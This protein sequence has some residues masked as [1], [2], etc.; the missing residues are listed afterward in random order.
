MYLLDHIVHFVEKPEHLIDQTKEIG[1]YTVNGGK[2]EMWGTYN[3]LCYFGLTYIEF[4]GIFNNELFERAAK[5]PYTLHET[6]KKSNRSNGFTRMALRTNSIE[7][8]ALRLRQVGLVVY[9]PETFSRTRPD[10]SVLTWKLLHIG[11]ENTKVEWPFLIQWEE[12][13]E[14]RLDDLVKRGTIGNHPLGDLR[15]SEVVYQVEDLQIPQKWADVFG[16]AI[17]KNDSCIT[18]RTSNC[19]F[20][21]NENLQEEGER[22]NIDQVV[23]SGAIE[24]KMVQLECGLYKFTK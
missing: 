15:I 14:A 17:E 5:E 24:E 4:I 9:G 7:E 2:H 18:L 6:Y 19:N 16:F 12:T 1:L 21:F 10:G 3:T 20:T 23:I 13:D 11:E 8:D 22:N